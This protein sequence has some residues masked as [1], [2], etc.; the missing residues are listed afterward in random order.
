M[1]QLKYKCIVID[2]DD[3]AFDSTPV[4]HYPA[5][6]RFCETDIMKAKE[7]YEV[8]TLQ[9]WYRMLWDWVFEEYLSKG[10]KL[11]KEEERIEYQMWREYTTQCHPKPFPGFIE[12]LKEYKEKGGIIVV[13]SHSHAEDV[14]RH[15]E[16]YDFVVDDIFGGV[17]GHPELCK[18]F[19]YPIDT[20]KQKYGLKND[21]IC[22]IDDLSPGFQMAKN[23]GVDAIGVL[24]GEGHELIEK[25]IKEMCK[26]IFHSVKELHDFLLQ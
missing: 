15:Y 2:H 6:L 9:G 11:T 7:G 18:P 17:R 12:M 23:A 21:D 5:Y 19:T 13:C 26:Y 22:V 10:M 8:L 20:I 24:Y 1:T 4:V 14:K 3:T 16:E 25:D